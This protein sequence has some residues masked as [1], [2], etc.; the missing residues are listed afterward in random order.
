MLDNLSS[1]PH[2]LI[3]TF[4]K[5]FPLTVGSCALLLTS[6]LWQQQWKVTFMMSCLVS[7]LTLETL[8]AVL[9]KSEALLEKPTW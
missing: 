3:H 4:V 5:S 1:G 8:R 6:R 9:R 7:R 2:D